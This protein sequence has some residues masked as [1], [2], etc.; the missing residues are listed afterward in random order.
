MRQSDPHL[1]PRDTCTPGT[2]RQGRCA[3]HR[4]CGA[5][6][7]PQ[8]PS[9]NS[10]AL[11][12]G[13]SA[14]PHDG[15]ALRAPTANLK[16]E[17]GISPGFQGS[18]PVSATPLTPPR[19]ESRF[20]PNGARRGGEEREGAEPA[21]SLKTHFPASESNPVQIRTGGARGGEADSTGSRPE[22]VLRRPRTSCLDASYARET[23]STTSSGDVLPCGL[24]D[25]PPL[26]RWPKPSKSA[27]I[28]AESSSPAAPLR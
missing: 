18:V 2:A 1:F 15:P 8:G 25:E 14:G 22:A 17:P 21:P 27:Y 16:S 24:P 7:R 28:A 6:E 3:A 11:Q 19:Q 13:D 9:P 23:R 12:M 5:S 4:S 10:A 20:T 26:P